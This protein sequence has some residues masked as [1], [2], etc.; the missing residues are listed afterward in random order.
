VAEQGTFKPDGLSAVV[1]A[2]KG[3]RKAHSYRLWSPAWRG[4]APGVEDRLIQ[5]Q[6]TES[7]RNLAAANFFKVI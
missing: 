6:V 4:V 7:G 2:W 5:S 3:E 1:G